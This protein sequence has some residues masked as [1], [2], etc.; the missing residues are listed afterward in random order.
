MTIATARSGSKL[1]QLG[2]H[3]FTYRDKSGLQG[4][5]NVA[6]RLTE[7]AR[8]EKENIKKAFTKQQKAYNMC[9]ST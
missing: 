5:Y 6:R 7:Q 3:T 9:S 2:K 1:P 8:K 4:M